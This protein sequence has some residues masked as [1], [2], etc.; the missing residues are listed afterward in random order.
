VAASEW[1]RRRTPPE[2]A[3]GR[4]D[5]VPAALSAAGLCMGFAAIYAAYAL[6]DLLPA[7]FAFAA[8]AAAAVAAILLSLLQGPFVA[9]LGIAGAYLVPALTSSEDPQVWPLFLYLL[10]VAATGAGVLYRRGW[11]W[12]AILNLAG[13]VAWPFLWF[14]SA[15]SEG[16]AAPIGIYVLGLAAIMVRLRPP[17]LLPALIGAAAI[18]VVAFALVRMDRYGPVS[19]ATLV[20]L[21]L[22][23]TGVGRIR[24]QVDTYAVLPP[25]L[26]SAL[27]AVWHLPLIWYTPEVR[28]PVVPPEL[29]GFVF[30]AAGFGLAFAVGGFVALWGA[31]RPGWWASISAGTPIAI[32]AIAYGRLS[33]FDLDWSWAALGLL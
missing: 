32:L 29:E 12:L 25:V 20:V 5:Y 11:A 19:M 23:F 16:D 27:L 17:A 3:G 8:L 26:V 13:A 24:Q 4:R 1:V 28:P 21:S 30:T 18:C 31:N 2:Q 33:D 10:F 14:M 6:Y 15:W 7:P 9:A 22:I